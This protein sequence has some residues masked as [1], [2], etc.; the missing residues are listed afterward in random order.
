M[1]TKKSDLTEV[2]KYKGEGKLITDKPSKP[3]K[4]KA[5]TKKDEPKKI[6]EDVS[7]IQDFSNKNQFNN[8]VMEGLP[9]ILKY[10][11][12]IIFDSERDKIDLLN[13]QDNY[14]T[15]KGIINNYDGLSFKFKR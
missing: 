6:E 9:F 12:I 5:E 3:L 2:Y 13:F 15:I 8:L 4:K 10:N 7:I 1:A 11:G 14:F